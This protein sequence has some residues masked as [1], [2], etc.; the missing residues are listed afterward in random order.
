[1]S[2]SAFALLLYGTWSLVLLFGN[3]LLRGVTT[4]SGRRNPRL[5]ELLANWSHCSC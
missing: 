3:M 4:A 2:H 5:I 1:M